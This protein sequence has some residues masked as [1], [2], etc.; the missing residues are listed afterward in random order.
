MSLKRIELLDTLTPAMVEEFRRVPRTTTEIELLIDSDGGFSRR[1][2]A[3]VSA[4]R[5]LK[6]YGVATTAVVIG[7][8]YSAAFII[9][10]ECDVRKALPLADLMFHAP[11]TLR[12]GKPGEGL[13]VDER[14][15]ESLIHIEFLDVLFKRTG[16]P[17][18]TLKE[19][20]DQEK[21]FT[22]DE[23]LRNRFIDEVVDG[24][25]YGK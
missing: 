10:Q 4:I 8:A 3:I 6:S 9:L 11:I 7:K 12:F 15:P 23:A 2:R 19:W 17:M 20:A 14:N 16:L 13:L 21:Y 24:S 22:A 5:Q 18:A 25:H 1:C